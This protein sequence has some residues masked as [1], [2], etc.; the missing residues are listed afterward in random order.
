MLDESSR[1]RHKTLVFRFPRPS[2][3]FQGWLA[4]DGGNHA[5]FV[6]PRGDVRT[7]G[8]ATWIVFSS[9][10]DPCR[11][12]HPRHHPPSLMHDVYMPMSPS[13]LNTSHDSC[14]STLLSAAPTTALNCAGDH[15]CICNLH[16]MPSYYEHLYAKLDALSGKRSG[17]LIVP[18][19]LD[20]GCLFSF[21]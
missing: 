21:S 17:P 8:M 13:P 19:V 4:G 20:R 14:I 12:L 11:L 2:S 15:G 1:A 10:L 3:C 18:A 16:I 6:Q 5:A 7:T 9:R